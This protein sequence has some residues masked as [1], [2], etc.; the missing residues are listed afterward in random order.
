[1]YIYIY[2]KFEENDLYI[3]FGVYKHKVSCSSGH[4]VT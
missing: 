1:M 3:Y 2:V 4:V